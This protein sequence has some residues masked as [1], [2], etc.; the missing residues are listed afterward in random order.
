MPRSAGQ[1][2][3]M[4]PAFHRPRVWKRQRLRDLPASCLRF[5]HP[6][7][8]RDRPTR[9]RSNGQNIN[10]PGPGR[11]PGS[12]ER[13]Q[14]NETF[15]L[16]GPRPTLGRKDRSVRSCGEWLSKLDQTAT[17]LSPPYFPTKRPSKPSQTWLPDRGDPD[18]DSRVSYQFLGLAYTDWAH[19]SPMKTLIVPEIQSHHPIRRTPIEW[20]GRR[21]KPCRIDGFSECHRRPR[22]PS[23]SCRLPSPHRYEGQRNLPDHYSTAAGTPTYR[24]TGNGPYG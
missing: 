4:P 21:R 16:M 14:H 9:T 10:L 13:L 5:K 24:A 3:G 20:I 15:P 23:Q 1:P 8:D 18:L 6:P 22:L 2:S 7:F 12:A 17:K 19:E 11:Q